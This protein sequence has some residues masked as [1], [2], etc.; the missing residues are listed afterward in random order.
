MKPYYKP[1]IKAIKDKKEEVIPKGY[2]CNEHSSAG[3]NECPFLQWRQ[4]SKQKLERCQELYKL[5]IPCGNTILQY[6]SLLKAY[7]RL[8][9][10]LKD[11]NINMESEGEE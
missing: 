4:V 8:Q 7:L 11:C 1:P 9:D 10:C 3:G 5:D 6:C 2:Y